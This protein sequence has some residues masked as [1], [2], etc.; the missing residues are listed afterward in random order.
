MVPNSGY[1]GPNRG[2][3]E[4]LG[5]RAMLGPQS[6]YTGT[7]SGLVVEPSKILFLIKKYSTPKGGYN[8]T[9]YRVPIVSPN[10]ILLKCLV[11]KARF[12]KWWS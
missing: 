7:P 2:W 3:E 10:K 4:G 11:S 9:L 12:H 8:L 5:F 1:L 6:S